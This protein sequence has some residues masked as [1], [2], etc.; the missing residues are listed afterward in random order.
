M[1]SHTQSNCTEEFLSTPFAD[2]P[3]TYHNREILIHLGTPDTPSILVI[4][5]W[6]WGVGDTL[7]EALD[8]CKDAGGATELRRRGYRIFRFDAQTEVFGVDNFGSHLYR[9]NPP[10]VDD[11]MMKKS[12]KP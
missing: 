4:T 2:R 8:A 10:E 11:S 6:Y 5:R 12:V 1:T 3:P 9:G 7:G